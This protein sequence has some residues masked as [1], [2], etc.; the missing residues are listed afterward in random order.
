MG[1]CS[2][3]SEKDKENTI[4]TKALLKTNA[5]DQLQFY[6][7]TESL[8]RIDADCLVLFCDEKMNFSKNHFV[9][10]V[11]KLETRKIKEFAD[12][13]LNTAKVKITPGQIV[14]FPI[15]IPTLQ[16]RLI[17]LVCLKI[18]DGHDRIRINLEPIMVN[19]F[20]DLNIQNITSLAIT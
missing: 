10:N 15:S 19:L 3:S 6:F 16:F 11:G 20:N 14:F 4:S 18:W 17:G 8:L 7:T 2:K 9:T 5:F 1:I 13:Y 12:S